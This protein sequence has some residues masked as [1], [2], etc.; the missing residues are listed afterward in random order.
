[1]RRLPLTR[2]AEFIIGRR[3]APT[4][5]QSDLSPQAGRGEEGT[6]GEVKKAAFLFPPPALAHRSFTIPH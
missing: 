6:R 1:M 3:F 2:I 4:R 5:W